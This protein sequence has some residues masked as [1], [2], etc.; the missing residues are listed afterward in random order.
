MAT[1]KQRAEKKKRLARPKVK[2]S[3]LPSTACAFLTASDTFLTYLDLWN[4]T[5]EAKRTACIQYYVGEMENR[6]TGL[7]VPLEET[8]DIIEL[9]DLDEEDDAAADSDPGMDDPGMNFQALQA[10]AYADELLPA[11]GSP[12]RAASEVQNSLVLY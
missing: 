2:V 6:L 10:P 4:M 7:R 5:A 8:I 1:T 3:R 11:F 12:V 9:P